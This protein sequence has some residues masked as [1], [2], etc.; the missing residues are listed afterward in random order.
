MAFVATESSP[1]HCCDHWS[2][3]WSMACRNY[4]SHGFEI[5]STTTVRY[6]GVRIAKASRPSRNYSTKQVIHFVLVDGFEYASTYDSFNM[7]RH[8]I[9]TV[10]GYHSRNLIPMYTPGLPSRLLSFLVRLKADYRT[11]LPACQTK[12]HRV[13]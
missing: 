2:A 10:N 9:L 4:R 3:L 8:R 13:R 12:R 7:W 6:Y 1:S 11:V 5:S